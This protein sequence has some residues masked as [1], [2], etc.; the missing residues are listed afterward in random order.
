MPM[1]TQSWSPGVLSPE[2]EYHLHVTIRRVLDWVGPELPTTTIAGDTFVQNLAFDYINT[3]SFTTSQS[4]HDADT[5]NQDWVIGDFEL[6]DYIDQWAAGHVG[7]FDLLDCID[8]WAA[9]HYYWDEASST[10]KP[11][12]E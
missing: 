6:L 1:T 4:Y 10:F 11:G 5:K 2:H 3:I 12:Y 7:D 8:L 9:G